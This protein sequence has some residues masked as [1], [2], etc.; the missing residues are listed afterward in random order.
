VTHR[1]KIVVKLL[2]DGYR[3]LSVVDTRTGKTTGPPFRSGPR[4]LEQTI[5]NLKQQLE[6]SGSQVEVKF[7]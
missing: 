1:C 7:L 6:R 5:K 2:D 3:E 4:D